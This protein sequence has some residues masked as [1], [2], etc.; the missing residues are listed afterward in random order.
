MLDTLGTHFH[1]DSSRN[2]TFGTCPRRAFAQDDKVQF[3]VIDRLGSER[4][5]LT[6]STALGRLV[7]D[8]LLKTTYAVFMSYSSICKKVYLHHSI[9]KEQ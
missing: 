9:A 6:A 4:V 5:I 7:R 8:I 3:K 1:H 2:S